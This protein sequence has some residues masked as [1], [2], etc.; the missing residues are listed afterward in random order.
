MCIDTDHLKIS[1]NLCCYPYI[2]EVYNTELEESIAA[3][4]N[5]EQTAVFKECVHGNSS[6]FCTGRGGTGKSSVTESV[7]RYFRN[8]QIEGTHQIA[9]TAS[10]GIAAY[11][12]KG[13][14]LHRFAGVGIMEDNKTEMYRK[15]TRGKSAQYWRKTDILVIDEISM[16]S[17]QFFDNLSY[18]AQKMR[19][20]DEPFGGIRLMM[21][22]DF[23]QLP[24]VAKHDVRVPRVFEGTVWKELSPK[25]FSLN[26]IMRQQDETFT[27]MVSKVRLGDCTSDVCDYFESLSRD[28]EYYDGIEPVRLYSLRKT[29]DAYN[30]SQLDKINIQPKVYESTDRGDERSLLQ[31]PA[32]KTL[33]LKSGSQVMLTR[34]LGKSAVNG[35]IGTVIGFKYVADMKSFQPLVKFIGHDG[36][37]FTMSIARCIWETIAP[38]GA[39]MSSRTQIPLILAWAITIHKSQGQTIP[40]LYVD[41]NRVFECGQAYVALSRCTDPSF[42]QVI[43]FSKD[44]VKV[45][46]ECLHYYEPI[47]EYAATSVARSTQ[48]RWDNNQADTLMMLGHLSIQETSPSTQET[49]PSSHQDSETS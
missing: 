25:V 12:I 28:I 32:P 43:G 26:K 21:F 13:I 5:E 19:K 31:C 48:E 45:D 42:L 27:E 4:L 15:A 33:K 14:T 34:N 47:Q 2:M 29:T 24:P 39:V 1:H 10:T 38:T 3:D 46:A 40:R 49:L 22:G 11:L 35:S 17:A 41:L 7:I 23:L 36:Q 44:I 16:I 18:V 20:S 37:S 8:V 9:V 6:V 30:Q